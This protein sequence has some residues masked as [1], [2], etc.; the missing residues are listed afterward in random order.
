MALV[1]SLDRW[2]ESARQLFQQWD[3][4]LARGM[5]TY[6]PIT[7]SCFGT[8]YKLPLWEEDDIEEALSHSNEALSELRGYLAV[9]PNDIAVRWT[10]LAFIYEVS[11][12]GE[13]EDDEDESD[14]SSWDDKDRAPFREE[15]GVLVALPDIAE[16]SDPKRVRWEIENSCIISDFRRAET[17]FLR[18]QE[19][20]PANAAFTCA[21]LGEF[22]LLRALSAKPEDIAYSALRLAPPAT[23]LAVRL[24]RWSVAV[25]DTSS[26]EDESGLKEARY[27]LEKAIEGG[28][29]LPGH[30][31]A[32]LA[33]CL[34]VEENYR[35]AGALFQAALDAGG[36]AL[37]GDQAGFNDELN[38]ALQLAIARSHER[39]GESA[40]AKA[41]LEKCLE[42]FPKYG[43]AFRRLAEQS[44]ADD[45]DYR[46]A[47]EA[48]VRW[49]DAEPQLDEDIWVRTLRGLGG[50]KTEPAVQRMLDEFFDAHPHRLQWVA[51]AV[52]SHWSVV[53]RLSEKARGQWLY[54]CW[55]LW[56]RP[57]GFEA[58]DH[59]AA[60][61]YFSRALEIELRERIFA[62]FV[63][64]VGDTTDLRVDIDRPRPNA[65]GKS[66]WRRLLD[67]KGTLG[68]MLT[69][70][71][72]SR[73]SVLLVS[74]R[75]KE[76]LKERFPRLAKSFVREEAERIKSLRNP[77]EHE[78][79]Q[80]RARAEEACALCRKY[81]EYLV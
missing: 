26:S 51:S 6:V 50:I 39:A 23:N 14:L 69:E 60:A 22:H 71:D 77:S 16:L 24:A 80:T 75:F 7:L 35:R 55:I 5:A 42:V 30:H 46:G 74:T 43:P 21:L 81:L 37:K 32:A 38:A 58:I 79:E 15:L 49:A 62:T 57:P 61:G 29:S 67:G 78:G 13:D 65:R 54:G 33:R 4:S 59:A 52:R 34:F 68:E 40:K 48:L 12:E 41:A 63:E 2:T 44:I 70:L 64:S 36:M 3:G 19:V 31:A 27:W 45:A 11:R 47:Y 28:V 8:I 9:S 56:W 18:A 72:P 20:D 73:D 25:D 76:W 17:L 1:E 53:D 10:I 66:A